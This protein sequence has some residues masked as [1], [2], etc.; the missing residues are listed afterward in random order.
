MCLPDVKTK[1]STVV[2][3]SSHVLLREEILGFVDLLM[4]DKKDF[5]AFPVYSSH[6]SQFHIL[7]IQ[8]GCIFKEEEFK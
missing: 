1:H 2:S 3:S 7:D 5:R 4:Q 6:L 8:N